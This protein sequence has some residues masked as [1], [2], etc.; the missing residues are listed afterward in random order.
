MRNRAKKIVFFLKNAK[1]IMAIIGKMRESN[2]N[3]MLSLP[4]KPKTANNT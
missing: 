2:V 1:Y 3:A 4:I